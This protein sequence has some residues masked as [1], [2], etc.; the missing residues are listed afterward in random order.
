MEDGIRYASIYTIQHKQL[1]F[2]AQLNGDSDGDAQ[3]LMGRMMA[4][5]QDLY[6]FVT[7]SYEV[8]RNTVQQM[9]VLHNPNK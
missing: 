1:S 9:S 2:S 4:T 6:S 3:V 8:I 7:R 5:L